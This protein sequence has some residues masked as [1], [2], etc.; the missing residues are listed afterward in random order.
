MYHPFF[1]FQV[2]YQNYPN[3][4]L[5]MLAALLFG[6]F[7]LPSDCV[8]KLPEGT[9]LLTLLR[10]VYNLSNE[11][12]QILYRSNRNKMGFCPTQK[13]MKVELLWCLG[14]LIFLSENGK[15]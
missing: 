3:H 6:E 8:L 10:E 5:E 7:E 14:D 15:P 9:S 1:F 11:A 13:Q 2:G 12:S 4:R